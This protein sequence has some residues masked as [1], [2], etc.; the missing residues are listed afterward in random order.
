[1]TPRGGSLVEF[2]FAGLENTLYETKIRSG[3]HYRSWN[4]TSERRVGEA[5]GGLVQFFKRAGF[6]AGDVCLGAGIGRF[7]NAS[8]ILLFIK[9]NGAST[10]TVYS[11]SDTGVSTTYTTPAW[12]ARTASRWSV[13]ASAEYLYC[14]N[15]DEGIWRKKIGDTSES[16]WRQVPTVLQSITRS[17]GESLIERPGEPWGADSYPKRLWSTTTETLTE[18]Q[19]FGGTSSSPTPSITNGNLTLS[20][21]ANT[22]GFVS[23]RQFAICTF[24]A[25]T[26][27][28]DERYFW[29]EAEIEADWG[30]IAAQDSPSFNFFEDCRVYVSTSA[31]AVPGLWSTQWK[32]GRLSW[33]AAE[34][35][36][37]KPGRYVRAICSV[38][39]DSTHGSSGTT[40]L[41]QI[42][43]IAI[44]L[45]VQ[46]KAG[47]QLT[48]SAIHQGGAFLNKPY[49]EDAMTPDPLLA[50]Y[51]QNLKDLEYVITF[52]NSS[53]ALESAPT[54][55]RIQRDFGFG[56]SVMDSSIPLGAWAKIDL[57][58]PASGYDR[59]RLYRKRHSDSGNWW[60][61][62]ELSSAQ[63]VIDA[64]VDAA[65]DPRSW[66][67]ILVRPENHDFGTFAAPIKGQCL[68]FW[69]GHLAVGV[70]PEVYLSY[71]F[72]PTRFVNPV[73]LT[74][75]GAVDLEDPT[76]GR[77]LHI[78]NDLGDKCLQLIAQDHL[79][80][81]GERGV[82]AMIG[83]SAVL[84]SP[85]RHI[86]GSLG[87][88]G[89]RACCAFRG[90]VLVASRT[91]L[92]FYR[93]NTGLVQS[94][95]T[96]FEAELV[97]A[98]VTESYDELL[99]R[100]ASSPVVVYE[101]AEDIWV[102]CGSYYLKRSRVGTWET[103]Q[104]S[105]DALTSGQAVSYSAESF[106][107]PQ[108]FVTLPGATGEEVTQGSL[109]TG[110][111]TNLPPAL[112]IT[113]LTTEHT[114]GVFACLSESS[115][116]L[117]GVSR[118]GIIF[119][120]DR[121]INGRKFRSDA[122]YAIPWV[123]RWPGMDIANRAT[124]MNLRFVAKDLHPTGSTNPVRLLLETFD[125]KQT[126]LF[127]VD[128]PPG[129]QINQFPFGSVA[130]GY[131]F[132]VALGCGSGS[133][134]VERLEMSLTGSTEGNAN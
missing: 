16:S 119:R 118:T 74:Q 21:V 36:P 95:V 19:Q 22:T 31:T 78:S 59:T 5:R 109:D 20:F 68:T 43:K 88:L 71:A 101:N 92:Y 85:F 46:S 93:A 50:P 122:G 62:E 82:Y 98:S 41:N 83:D 4:A 18:Y 97:S 124:A 35:S 115:L 72:E 129:T 33:I 128:R 67:A 91:G 106:G 125:G 53:T 10:V 87:A 30:A 64:R 117:L 17:E 80:A 37:N 15:A 42:R 103:G 75:P 27:W 60:L 12:T 13:H 55:L 133:Q 69:N 131:R 32:Q 112:P 44:G 96:G 86:P 113:P 81:V 134:L 8:E 39:L 105:P 57:P 127:G 76:L 108:G 90:G 77:T 61:I 84:A 130:S 110:F 70:G 11:V 63:L 34:E 121:D 45:P 99:L 65:V 73:R 2:P 89:P 66:N 79:Y 104:F 114:Q 100:G 120:M 123:V 3:F 6:H 52:Y 126:K 47:F 94:N 48:Y 132:T 40:T 23:W 102:F 25:A 51:A 58:A 26:N 107:T 28:L 56:L 49:F 7:G 9:R 14:T 38:D 116:G 111:F 24:A 54:P 29:F 1:M